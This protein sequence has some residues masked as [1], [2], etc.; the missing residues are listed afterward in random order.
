MDFVFELK[1]VATEN[2]GKYLKSGVTQL[3]KNGLVKKGGIPILVL[4]QENF[5]KWKASASKEQIKSAEESIEKLEKLGGGLQ[6]ELGLN[7]RA[8]KR[9]NSYFEK[10]RKTTK[11]PPAN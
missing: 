9:L 11:E 5:E 2:I 1:T 4:D 6:L 3:T 7:K 8:V 10:I